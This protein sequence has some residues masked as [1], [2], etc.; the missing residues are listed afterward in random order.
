MKATVAAAAA[1]MAGRD[2]RGVARNDFSSPEDISAP[3]NM[4]IGN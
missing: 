3:G 2:G 4:D 1:A